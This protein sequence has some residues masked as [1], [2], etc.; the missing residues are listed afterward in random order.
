MKQQTCISKAKQG[1][2]LVTVLLLVALLTIILVAFS[3]LLNISLT[4]SENAELRAQARQNAVAA[5][6][7]AL[8]ELQKDMG[9]DQRVSAMATLFDNDPTTQQIEGVNQPFWTGVWKTTRT[10]TG[11]NGLLLPA[12]SGS[13]VPS[14][15]YS[16]GSSGFKSQNFVRWLVSAPSTGSGDTTLADQNQDLPKT[17]SLDDSNSVILVGNGSVKSGTALVSSGSIEVRAWKLDGDKDYAGRQGRYA[18]WVGDEGVK[19]KINLESPVS[20]TASTL[21]L[22]QALAASPRNAVEAV[23]TYQGYST[24]TGDATKAVTFG[25]LPWAYKNVG[26][27][28]DF[29][30]AFFD[31]TTYSQGV[32]ADVQNGGLRKDLNLLLE[33]PT[34][35]LPAFVYNQSAGNGPNGVSL[36]PFQPIYYRPYTDS[37]G[38][39]Y[40]SPSYD[41]SNPASANKAMG[42]DWG[43]V[44]R[45]YNLYK[46]PYLYQDTDGVYTFYFDRYNAE[47]LYSGARDCIIPQTLK[48]QYLY[49]FFYRGGQNYEYPTVQNSGTYQPPPTYSQLYLSC[50]PVVHLWNP[51]NVR[52]R[53]S[54]TAENTTGYPSLGANAGRLAG[55]V[56]SIPSKSIS[57]SFDGGSTWRDLLGTSD[58]TSVF[59]PY[60]G[61]LCTIWLAS[62]NASSVGLPFKW[63]PGSVQVFGI[64]QLSTSGT[65]T[66]LD[67]KYYKG[68][69]QAGNPTTLRSPTR[70]YNLV[71]GYKA[72]K[73]K[74]N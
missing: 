70:A 15:Y 1:F 27:P 20:G 18:W 12:W 73:S 16:S 71:Y 53:N 59:Q 9:P 2:S 4:S 28:G 51:Y 55:E 43:L 3:A 8:G 13:D 58:A 17:A 66:E 45:Y 47:V 11:T 44:Y 35:Q 14:N 62:G 30:N 36:Y 19:A 42:P 31:F 22:Q 56:I 72:E 67:T 65:I 68:H 29:S 37:L 61:S 41:P 64:E 54:T 39:V 24:Q 26:N 10:Q 60:G 49:G 38:N 50:V 32:L 69:Y 33:L 6:G 63:N 52:L 21:Q 48:S 40:P 34:S 46:S 7:M 57:I 74:Q 23:Q 25:S 5:M